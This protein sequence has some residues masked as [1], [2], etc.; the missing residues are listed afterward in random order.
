MD[1]A[2]LAA[3]R[4]LLRLLV[5]PR[6]YRPAMAAITGAGAAWSRATRTAWCP[7]PRPGT[8]PPA[9]AWQYLELPGVGHVPQLQVP[10]RL[11]DGGPRLARRRPRRPARRSEPAQDPVAQRV[12]QGLEPGVARP[13][14][15][16]LARL[17]GVH[18]HRPAGRLDP[19]GDRRQ[20]RQPGERPGRRLRGPGRQRDRQRRRTR[21]RR[22][23]R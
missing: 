16:L 14:A 12:A 21:G 8:S 10:E 7:S 13:P 1:R 18:D 22:R 2:F 23:P 19:L 9:P 6:S 3:A 17:R 11:A 20:E 4:S 5:D 15:Q